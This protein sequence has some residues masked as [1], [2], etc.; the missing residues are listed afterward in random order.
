MSESSRK[1]SLSVIVPCY[2][3]DQYLDRSLACLSRQWDGRTDYEIILVNDASTDNTLVKLNGFK[4]RYPENVIVIN[5]TVNGGA[6]E[7]RNSGLDEAKGE[8]IVFFDPDD[9]LVDNGYGLLLRLV[10]SD[11]MDILSFGVNHVNDSEWKSELTQIG[12]G[13][14]QIE[15]RGTGQEYVQKGFSG[16]CWRFLFRR[17]VLE[18]RKFQSMFFL[19]DLVFVLP[20]FLSKIK[21]AKT[22]TIIYYY[23]V[24]QSSATTMIDP[25]KLNRGCDD[26]LMAIQFMDQCKQGQNEK[27]NTLIE[28]R[29]RFYRYNLIA[30]LMLS[31]K[32]LTDLKRHRDSI[33]ALSIPQNSS[34]GKNRLFDFVF[35]HPMVMMLLRPIYRAIRTRRC[36]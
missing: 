3:V 22:E 17:S 29:Q 11:D 14:L 31:D 19:E 8:W 34:T 30:R 35:E 13:N 4:S 5:K 32:G 36:R 7:A 1:I 23:I 27:V 20:V 26:I 12:L 6:A 15:W 18:G 2:N 9:A 16:V 24:R 28:E 21:V 33:K 10:E 25:H